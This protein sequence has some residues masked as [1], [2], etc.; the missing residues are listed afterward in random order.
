VAI[1]GPVKIELV[2]EYGDG[3]KEVE[4]TKLE[5]ASSTA[6]PFKTANEEDND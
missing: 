6:W 5:S 4:P 3:G 2:D 1:L